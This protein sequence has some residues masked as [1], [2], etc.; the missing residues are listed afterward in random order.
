MKMGSIQGSAQTSGFQN[1]IVLDSFQWGFAAGY[2]ARQANSEVSIREVV[3]TMRAEKA[4]PLIVNAGVSRTILTP[5]VTVKFTTTTKDAVVTFLSY[6]FSN[7]VIT[8]YSISGPAEGVPIETLSLSFTKIT[9][10]F[11]PKDSSMSGSPT[12]VTYD[13]RSAQSS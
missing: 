4:S 8:N 11:S 1:W 2:T 10:T 3:V 13:V 9:E 12:T 6:D 5:T 7:C